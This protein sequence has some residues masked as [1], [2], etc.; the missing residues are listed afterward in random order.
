MEEKMMILK[1]LQEGKITTDEALKLL[2]ALDKGGSEA[3]TSAGPRVNDF[4]EDFTAKLNEMKIDEKISKFGEKAAKFA[5]TLGERAGKFAGQIN[6]RIENEKLNGNAER[7][8]EEFAKRVENLGHDIAESAG[9]LADTFT[10]QFGNIFDIGYEKYTSSYTYPIESNPNIDLDANNFS[11]KVFPGDI[12]NIIVNINANSN[13]SQLAIDEYFKAVID[14]NH[15]KLSCELPGKSWGKIEMLVPQSLEAL[16]L[17]TDNGKCEVS[18]I[19]AKT[20]KCNTNNGKVYISKCDSNE[21]EV[22]TDNGRIVLEKSSAKLAN[23]RTSNAKIEISDCKLDNID[24][25][26]TNATIE[27]NELYKKEDM[28]AKYVLNTSNGRI[29]IELGMTEGCEYA[30]DAATTMGTIDIALPNLVSTLDRKNIGM[31]SR[32]SVKSSNFDTASNKLYIKANTSNG[33]IN[34]ENKK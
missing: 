34:I 19:Q 33:A 24:A 29:N 26:T 22:L 28:D 17:Y 12:Q 21:I 31:Q 5:E 20:L 3:K 25:K 14:G 9:R 8:T 1:M 6:E 30:V 4:K 11:I 7:F 13:V 10:S 32:A 15:C 2:E 18:E 23:I 27:A 16:N